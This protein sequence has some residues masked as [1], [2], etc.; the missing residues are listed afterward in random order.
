MHILYY[1]GG[2]TDKFAVALHDGGS[3]YLRVYDPKFE[4]Y[5]VTD[6]RNAE[7]LLKSGLWSDTQ[8]PTVTEVT[9]KPKPPR[10]K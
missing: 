6:D 1:V 5:L 2:S 4:S 3:A 7:I 8:E 10:K 9:P